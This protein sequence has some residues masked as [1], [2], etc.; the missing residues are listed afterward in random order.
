[1]AGKNLFVD[2]ISFEED[3][4]MGELPISE[5]EAL[6]DKFKPEYGNLEKDITYLDLQISGVQK[7]IILLESTISSIEQLLNNKSNPNIDRSKFY[8]VLNKTIELLAAYHSN[9][10]RFLDLKF[11][12]RKEQDDLKFRIVRM[13]NIEL[14]STK[15]NNNQYSDMLETLKNFNFDDKNAMGSLKSEIDSINNDPIY[16]M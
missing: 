13:I 10:Q 2:D 12:Y 1:M 9:V 15:K 14:E 16:E 4:N 7:H 3:D 8:N 5:D 6:E 11:K